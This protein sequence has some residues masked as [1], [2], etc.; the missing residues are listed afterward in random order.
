MVK[1]EMEDFLCICK[2][3]KL[4][5]RVRRGG[6]NAQILQLLRPSRL[7]IMVRAKFQHPSK[8]A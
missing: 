7:K 5:D 3:E 4:N 2:N 1:F 8:D 6:K